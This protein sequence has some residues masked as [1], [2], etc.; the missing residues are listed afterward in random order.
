MSRSKEAERCAKVL[1]AMVKEKGNRNCADCGARTPTW[2]SCNIGVFICIRCSGIHRRLGVHISFVKS[3]TLD[4]WN[5]Y[6]LKRFKAQ[7]GNNR[8]NS[9]YEAMLPKELK[10]NASSDSNTVEDFIRKK[11]EKK[12]WYSAEKA[13][14]TAAAARSKSEGVGGDKGSRSSSSLRRT[15]VQ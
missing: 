4:S 10:P 11:Y 1:A 2:T 14:A 5:D 7:G 8:V 3:I 9:R 6:Y 12:L 13:K 15:E